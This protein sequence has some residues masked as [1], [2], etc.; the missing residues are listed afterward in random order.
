[1]NLKNQ[2]INSIIFLFNI[3][4]LKITSD[5]ILPQNLVFMKITTLICK[6]SF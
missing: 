5:F 1:M 3:F 4:V 6:N 2:V